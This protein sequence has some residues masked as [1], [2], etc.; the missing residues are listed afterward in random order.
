MRAAV[1]AKDTKVCR[2][3]SV[4]DRFL[5]W[6]LGKQPSRMHTEQGERV[7]YKHPYCWRLYLRF[8]GPCGSK[9]VSIHSTNSTQAGRQRMWCCSTAAA[10]HSSAMRGSRTVSRDRN[11]F[12][13]T[14]CR[15]IDVS[16]YEANPQ[17]HP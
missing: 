14:R 2:T 12:T 1:E 7:A 3:V 15:L 10:A 6:S 8:V 17:G 16:V 13:G 11:S 5:E 4:T 9:R